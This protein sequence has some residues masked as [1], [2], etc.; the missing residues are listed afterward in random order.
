MIITETIEYVNLPVKELQRA[1][2]FY[3]NLF[4]FELL[5]KNDDLQFA[6]L[7]YNDTKIRLIKREDVEYGE[8]PVLSFCID[9]DDFSEAID[10][11]EE[12]EIEIV[13]G[14]EVTE[15]GGE[16]VYIRD[17]AGNLLELFY[18]N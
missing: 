14:P 2:D 11:L 9:I 5:E 7:S 6:I 1:T 13:K 4:D 17:T 16:I 3:I 15:D 18:K 10:E 8:F 12:K